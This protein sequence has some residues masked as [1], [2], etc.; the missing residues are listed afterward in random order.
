MFLDKWKQYI[1][2]E[3]KYLLILIYNYKS[4]YIY[5][6]FLYKIIDIYSWNTGDI[7]HFFL[8]CKQWQSLQGG[9]DTIPGI[10][11]RF[12]PENF[13]TVVCEEHKKAIIFLFSL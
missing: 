7:Y 1:K 10:F 6:I 13:W 2:S 8:L 4:I 12:N 11:L 9:G 5:I 3:I